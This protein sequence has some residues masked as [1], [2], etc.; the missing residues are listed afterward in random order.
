MQT[1]NFF[2][3]KYLNFA[4]RGILLPGAAALLAQF[5]LRPCN[6]RQHFNIILQSTPSCQVFC[7]L[8]FFQEK[9]L[10]GMS[11]S[12]ILRSIEW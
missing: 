6:N 5:L 9:Q 1:I 2:Y 8:L 12:G 11:S 3:L 10:G 4:D 7:P